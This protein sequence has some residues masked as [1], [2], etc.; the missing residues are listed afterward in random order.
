MEKDPVCG[1]KVEPANAAGTS[2]Y[3]GQ[4]YYFCSDSC[5]QAFDRYPDAYV[6]TA[7]QQRQPTKDQVV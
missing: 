4:T 3:R 5:K 7:D 2:A 1:M 6:A